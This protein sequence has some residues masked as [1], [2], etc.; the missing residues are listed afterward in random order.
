MYFF[1]HFCMKKTWHFVWLIPIG[2]NSHEKAKKIRHD[3][4][5]DGNDFGN[6]SKEISSYFSQTIK[7]LFVLRFYGPVYPMGSCWARSVYLTTRFL[8]RLSPLSS[9][10]VLCT[11]FRQTIKT[12][13]CPLLIFKFGRLKVKFSMPEIKAVYLWNRHPEPS[14]PS[15]Y[16]IR[17]H[18]LNLS[19]QNKI[20]FIIYHIIFRICLF[21][22]WALS[23]MYQWRPTQAYTSLQSGHDLWNPSFR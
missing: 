3:I 8:G 9:S 18:L 5:C 20:K 17:F 13:K 6:N 1:S 14:S 23:H 16:Q 4:S 15:T 21:M 11:F 12:L 10:P 19:K 2:E 7:T 22:K